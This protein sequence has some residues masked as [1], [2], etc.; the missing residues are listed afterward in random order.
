MKLLFRLLAIPF[1]VALS[2]GGNASAAPG[3]TTITVTTTADEFNLSGLGTG[4]SLREA[5][6]SANAAPISGCATAIS[7]PVTISI[8]AGIYS[9]TLTGV[10]DDAGATGDLDVL[11]GLAIDGMGPDETIID[12]N[13]TDRVFDVL[14]GDAAL[15]M[16]RDMTIRNGDSA[17]NGGG[18]RNNANLILDNVVI[19]SNHVAGHGGG[20]YNKSGL[21]ATSPPLAGVG[22]SGAP[23]VDMAITQ[24]TVKDSIITENEADENGGGLMNDEAS[25]LFIMDS[26]I[27]NN[28]SDADMDGN[29]FGGGIYN[30]SD[31]IFDLLSTSVMDNTAGQGWG[32]GLFSR[33]PTSD[34]VT[35]SNALFSGNEAT[36]NAGGNIYHDYGRMEIS[37]SEISE[38]TASWGGGLMTAVDGTL[39]SIEN[40]TFSGNQAVGGVNMGGAIYVH[41]GSVEI[42]HATIVNNIADTGAGIDHISTLGSVTIKSSIVAHNTTA[43]DVLANFQGYEL[44]SLGYNLTDGSA[45]YPLAAGDLINTDPLLGGYGLN[46]AFL[47]HTFSLLSGSPAIDAAD[48]LTGP[49]LDQRGDPRPVD[50]DRDGIAIRDIGA[51]ELQL[52][53]FLPLILR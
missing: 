3:A 10:G 28:T 24:T 14:A 46:G 21:G 45:W 1:L 34:H 26:V 50:G 43:G 12:G 6:H 37:F 48:P 38:G 47:T 44:T 33:G 32:G 18:I 4:C 20:I 13:G 19:Q 29:G 16:V 11:E 39:T 52:E 31:E 53:L 7:L 51:F 8:P 17:S 30:Y 42:L 23:G 15:V 5:I 25:S 49:D 22:M 35:I 9:L 2:I 40:V 36:S 27:S 41:S